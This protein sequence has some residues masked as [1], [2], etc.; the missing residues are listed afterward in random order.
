MR[1]GLAAVVV[2]RELEQVD[3]RRADLRAPVPAR[4]PS[5]LAG[6]RL[7][8]L[9]RRGK[10]LVWHFDGGVVLLCHLGMSGRLLLTQGPEARL[11]PHDHV[12]FLF[13]GGATVT[14]RDPRRF[15]RMDLTTEAK[16]TRH[17]LLAGMGPEPLGPDFDGPYLATVLAGRKAPIKT[18]L[19]DQGVVAGLGNIYACEALFRARLSPRRKAAT[20]IGARARRLAGSV[21]EVLRDAIAAGGSS[22]NDY[23]QATGEAGYF[24]HRF[25]VYARAGERCPQCEAGGDC[26]VR[27]IVQSGRSTFYCPRRQR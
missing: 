22:I 19:M 9:S 7:H 4:F 12:R 21:T 26:R 14:F 2:G 10:Y 16:L 18:A 6:R 11:G 23:V 27:R 13:A 25:A 15:G 24:Q 3:Q 5:R 1:A 17:K 20:V 8:D